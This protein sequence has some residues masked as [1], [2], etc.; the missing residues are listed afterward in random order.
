MEEQKNN[1]NCSYCNYLTTNKHNW[2]KHLETQK[3]L[4]ILDISVTT[5]ILQKKIEKMKSQK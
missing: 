2:K 5:L 3:H 1:F 4:K